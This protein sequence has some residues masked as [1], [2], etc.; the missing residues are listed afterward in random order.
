MNN[1]TPVLWV[2]MNKTRTVSGNEEGAE[3][4]WLPEQVGDCHANSDPSNASENCP[5]H[6][7]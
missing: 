4:R 7:D 1:L 3:G 5:L 2:R 6:S